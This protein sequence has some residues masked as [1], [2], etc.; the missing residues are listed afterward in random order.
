MDTVSNTSPR[1][2]RVLGGGAFCEVGLPTRVE[3]GSHKV[4]VGG[5]AGVPQ[6]PGYDA[7]RSKGRTRWHR[8]GVYDLAT[9]ECE[10]LVQLRW[11]PLALKFHPERAL[12]AIGSGSYDGGYLFEGEL[13]LLDLET[14]VAASVLDRNREVLDV[15]WGESGELRL[16]VS[17][18]DEEAPPGPFE[19]VL[20]YEFWSELEE[21]STPID[22]LTDGVVARPV[23]P[24][25]PGPTL[26]EL[27]S[28]AGAERTVRRVVW[29]VLPV[30]GSVL[31]SLDGVAVERWNADDSLG[32]RTHA[33]GV[34]CQLIT[35]SG[36]VVT[37]VIPTKAH[38]N[39][40][41]KRPPSTVSVVDPGN[42]SLTPLLAPEQP[43]VLASADGRLLART[44]EYGEP[45]S[46]STIL[47]PDGSASEIKLG[48]Y[49]LFNHYLSVAGAPHLLVLEG[50]EPKPWLNKWV[51]RLDAA[52]ERRRRSP[53]FVRTRLFPLEWD[54][55]RGAQVMSGPSAY[56]DDRSG[57]SIIHGGLI[58]SPRVGDCDSFVVRRRYPSGEL[59]WEH[60]DQAQAVGLAHAAERVV[61]GLISG[62]V[63]VLDCSSGDVVDRFTLT[64][65][66]HVAIPL[67]IATTTHRTV[68]IGTLDGRIVELQLESLSSGR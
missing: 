51:V 42:G 50:D 52:R 22:D 41:L 35:H 30:D 67:S 61:V 54:V 5:H 15:A 8:V 26:D 9:L 32:F 39:Y 2:L 6:W 59:Q 68:V 36:S 46:P 7:Q 44:C 21:S 23:E 10:A 29:S 28:A 37:N 34:G 19:A 20:P 62:E 45:Q 57:P 60:R 65:G 47:E 31:A 58:H 11:P 13:T 4:A 14:G 16:V 53:S 40:R 56:V 17:P 55:S 27:C 43:V 12:L 24:E 33:D 48:R 63:V 49:D 38:P 66:R 3:V 64:I 25:D 1:T 18:T